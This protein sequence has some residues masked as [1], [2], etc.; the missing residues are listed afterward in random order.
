MKP[1]QFL[2]NI[3]QKTHVATPLPHALS[4]LPGA[5]ARSAPA[6]GSSSL[7]ILKHINGQ[8]HNGADSQIDQYPYQRAPFVV[9][10]PELVHRG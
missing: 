1:V 3:N 10:P 4:Y 9:C 7:L 8:K 2:F 5:G 6:L